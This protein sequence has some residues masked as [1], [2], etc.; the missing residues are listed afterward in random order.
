MV[1]AACSAGTVSRN[2]PGTLL[3]SSSSRTSDPSALRTSSV[4]GP[5]TLIRIFDF[6]SSH[7]IIRP[8]M[9]RRPR[10]VSLRYQALWR[11][12]SAFSI[13]NATKPSA[14]R[15]IASD[16][17][18]SSVLRIRSSTP[19]RRIHAPSATLKSGRGLITC[20]VPS[21]T[22]LP[23]LAY[24]G[25]RTFQKGD[26]DRRGR[27]AEEI[28]STRGDHES[29]GPH[30]LK[31]TSLPQVG[32]RPCDA[33]VQPHLPTSEKLCSIL[34]RESELVGEPLHCL[35]QRPDR[36]DASVALPFHGSLT[37]RA[38]R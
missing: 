26:V 19:A 16:G 7:A 12:S 34:L 1:F 5:M 14:S 11:S 37:S 4:T 20:N 25:E 22:P 38:S 35:C 36:F 15:R 6:S 8:V 17:P 10:S 31:N 30:A 27:V 23:E 28:T 18:P 21:R 32:A 9:S 13:A 3:N 29:T 24:L 2:P 33:V